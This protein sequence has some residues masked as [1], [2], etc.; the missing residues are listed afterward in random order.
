[1]IKKIT[2]IAVALLMVLSFAVIGVSASDPDTQVTIPADAATVEVSGVLYK[3][4]RTADDFKAINDVKDNYILANDIDFAGAAFED[5]RIVRVA[6]GTV[7][8]GN[9]YALLN[10]SVTGNGDVST[11]GLVK[12]DCIYIKNLTVGSSSAPISITSTVEGKSVGA[13]L[14]YS[15]SVSSWENVD[16]YANVSANTSGSNT[17]GL[18][19]NAKGNHTLKNVTFNG[20]VSGKVTGGLIGIANANDTV[21]TL[22]DCV[23]NGVVTGT[24]DTGGIIGKNT[25]QTTAT[26]C[27]NLGAVTSTGG[28]GGFCGSV[29]CVI[30][31]DK[32]LGVGKVQG[33]N[34]VGGIYGYC[35]GNGS[36]TNNSYVVGTV[37][38]SNTFVGGMLAFSKSTYTVKDSGFFG[39]LV[40]TNT[41]DAKTWGV[42]CG[43]ITDDTLK[44][45]SGNV[46][47]AVEGAT[48]NVG[49]SDGQ[50]AIS[51]ADAAE[52]LNTVFTDY[53]FAVENGAIVVMAKQ[54]PTGDS[55][56]VMIVVALTVSLVG[57]LGIAIYSKKRI[58]E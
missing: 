36:I 56:P 45:A 12:G 17:G 41:G 31:L 33:Q 9:G 38:S 22:N 13:L 21:F 51:Q 14:S 35:G 54:P 40:V 29:S 1:M 5:N 4:I 23:N 47:T 24:N 49:L 42:I 44:E 18:I 19:G 58:A 52:K 55:F 34:N 15:N 3:V 28:A 10:Y 7:I 20:S 37:E 39:N 26:N 53:S 43:K 32:F 48:I 16:V 30:T 8:D 25:A 6:A 46:F 50:A 11:F 57:A 27:I 2:A